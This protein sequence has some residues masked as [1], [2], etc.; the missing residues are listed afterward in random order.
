[1]RK[2]A[3]LT[4][5]VVIVTAAVAVPAFALQGA[6]LDGNAHPYT[7]LSVYPTADP[8]FVNICSGTL[9][10]PSIYITAGHCAGKDPSGFQPDIAFLYFSG[11]PNPSQPDSFGF[12]VADPG[13]TGSLT[14]GDTHDIG[15]VRLAIPAPGPYAQIAP[16]GYVD[17]LTRARGQKNVNFT[18]VGYGV[19]DIAPKSELFD[20]QRRQGTTQLQTTDGYN[21]RM[22]DAPGNGT[23]GSGTCYGDSGGSVLQGNTLV[24]VISFGTK[25]CMGTSGAYRVDTPG[26]RAFLASQGVALP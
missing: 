6:S 1:M 9:V 11:S 23:G 10:S 15:V 12:P 13:W 26:A 3:L 20:F 5:V 8:N 22:T 4:I 24:A 7:A 18:A 16:A 14:K 2:R 25:Y 21:L 19:Y 17:G